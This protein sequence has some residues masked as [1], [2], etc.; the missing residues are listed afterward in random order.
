MHMQD[1]CMADLNQALN[2]SMAGPAEVDVDG[3]KQVE[4]KLSDQIAAVRFAM[5]TRARS[6]GILAG[7]MIG[8]LAAPGTVF[9]NT[10]N[11]LPLNRGDPGL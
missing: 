11:N 5:A 9:P 10:R 2:G 8:G 7:C 4:H 3:Q 1:A 6:Q